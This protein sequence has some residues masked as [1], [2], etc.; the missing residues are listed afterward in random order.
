MQPLGHASKGRV[1]DP[2]IHLPLIRLPIIQL[3]RIVW[4]VDVL[5]VISDHCP[6]C[7]Q[8]VRIAMM[9]DYDM[10]PPFRRLAREQR[11]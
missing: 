1:V 3:C 7:A 4:P 11:S 5:I 6:H 10:V 2:V 9:R 8:A